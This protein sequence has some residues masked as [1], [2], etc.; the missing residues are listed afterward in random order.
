MCQ[1]SWSL[2]GAAPRGVNSLRLWPATSHTCR[3]NRLGGF[4]QPSTKAMWCQELGEVRVQAGPDGF[5]LQGHSRKKFRV[6]PA[7]ASSSAF[8][9]F[10]FTSPAFKWRH[11]AA[12]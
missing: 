8:I 2:A 1:L 6:F 11:T 7:L 12:L 3:Q 5:C 4:G 10:V 9:P